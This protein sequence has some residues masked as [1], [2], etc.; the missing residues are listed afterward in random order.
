MEEASV[1]EWFEAFQQAGGKGKLFITEPYQKNGHAVIGAPSY[2]M[3]ALM[4]Y[5]AEIKLLQH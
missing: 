1:R 4:G 5:L 2:F 3:D